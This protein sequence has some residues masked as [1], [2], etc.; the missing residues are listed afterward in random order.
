MIKVVAGRLHLRTS[1]NIRRIIHFGGGCEPMGLA[2]EM[3]KREGYDVHCIEGVHAFPRRTS[4]RRRSRS[5]STNSSAL[6]S[7]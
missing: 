5:W 7:G 3:M 6:P 2:I 4:A 1:Q